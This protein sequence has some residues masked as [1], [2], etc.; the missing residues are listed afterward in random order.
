MPSF[1]LKL[2]NHEEIEKEERERRGGER[3]GEERRGEEKGKGEGEGE[4][5]G[6]GKGEGEGEGEEEAGEEPLV[7][8]EVLLFAG[9]HCKA[10]QYKKPTRYDSAAQLKLRYSQEELKKKHREV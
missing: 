7:L 2:W 4:G 5:E 3:R 9:L 1:I 8:L 6:E 10:P